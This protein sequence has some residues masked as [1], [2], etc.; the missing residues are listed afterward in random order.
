[1]SLTG[2]Y[3]LGLILLALVGVACLIVLTTFNRPRTEPA[4]GLV[5]S[6]PRS[7]VGHR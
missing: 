1:M 2:S 5:A 7:A 6:E 3:A 4:P